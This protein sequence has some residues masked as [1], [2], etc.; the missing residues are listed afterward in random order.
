MLPPQF[1]CGTNLLT[2]TT[3]GDNG[4][5]VEFQ[6]LTY[7]VPGNWAS[8]KVITIPANKRAQ[9]VLIPARQQKTDSKAYDQL[10]SDYQV[11][12]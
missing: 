10:E 12:T 11:P 9:M 5:L 2:L 4:N 8:T 3:A 6:V 1:D 7:T